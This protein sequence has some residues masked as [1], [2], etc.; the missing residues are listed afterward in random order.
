MSFSLTKLVAEYCAK[1]RHP[2]LE[3][4]IV[5]EVQPWKGWW[6]SANS[7]KPGCYVIY[8]RDGVPIYIGKA[9]LRATMGSRLAVHERSTDTKWADAGF[10]QMVEVR[11]AYE[12]PSLEE[13]LLGRIYTRENN[14]GRRRTGL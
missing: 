14:I 8:S 7:R 12:A 3:P 13:F 1:K 2:Q 11:E 6:G 9:S 10:V 5:H 4:F